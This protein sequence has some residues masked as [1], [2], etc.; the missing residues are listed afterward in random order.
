MAIRKL[1]GP[2]AIVYEREGQ[3]RSAI[4][5]VTA[6]QRFTK[7]SGDSPTTVGAIGVSPAD[8][9]GPTQY[10]P[11]TAVP[12]TFTFTGDLAVELGKSLAKIPTKVGRTGARHRRWRA[13][14]GDADQRGR[15]LHHRR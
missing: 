8:P 15:G 11:L 10:N 4:V 3:Q 2:V 14:P 1:D 13:R 12:A 5:D 7:D 6:T 9:P